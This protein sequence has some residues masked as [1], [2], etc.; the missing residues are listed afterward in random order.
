MEARCSESGTISFNREMF[1][2]KVFF[3]LP[4]DLSFGSCLIFNFLMDI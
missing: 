3:H 4:F 2:L 1:S